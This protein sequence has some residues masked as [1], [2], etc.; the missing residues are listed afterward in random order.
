MVSVITGDIVNSRQVKNPDIWLKPLKEVFKTFSLS[1]Q[2]WELYRGDSFQIELKQNNNAFVAVVLIKATIKM[3]KGLDVRMAIGVGQKDHHGSKVTESNGP[4]FIYSGEAFESLKS[5][6]TNLAIKTDHS[7]LDNELN[8]YFKLA[9]IAM[10]NWTTNASEIVKLSLENPKYS[11]KE[12]GELAGVK[13]NTVSE[14]LKRA[15][16]NEITE[17]SQMYQTK[18]KTLI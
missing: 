4:A 15:F 18:I 6:R 17:L 12:I 8:L 13:Q 10:D 1:E 9:L 3:I 11:Q 16:F 14:H 7:K 2:Y 5:K